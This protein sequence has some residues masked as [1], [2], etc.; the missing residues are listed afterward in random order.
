MRNVI[1]GLL[2]AAVLLAQSKLPKGDGAPLP[3]AKAPAPPLTSAANSG[4]SSGQGFYRMKLVKV[5]DNEGF[6]PNVEAAR[7]LIPADW[8]VEGGVH[9]VGG[10]LGCP[11]NI[12][13]VNFKAT[14]PDGVTG[15]EFGPGYSWAS[16]SDPQGMRIIQQ[17]AAQKQGCDGGPVAGPI[18]Y[19]AGESCRSIAQARAFW[20]A[21]RCPT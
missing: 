4:P 6:G 7:L 5:I 11:S 16:S 12:I 3:A 18:D 14:A 19:C 13:Q 10:Q 1:F 15:I 8:K 21:S 2:L 9:W 20:A 17:L